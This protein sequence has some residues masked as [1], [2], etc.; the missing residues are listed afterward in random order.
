MRM[1]WVL[2]VVL[3]VGAASAQ[4]QIKGA[5]STFAANLYASWGQA[6]AKTDSRLEYEPIGS[7]GGVKAVQERIT[8][9]GA[10]DRPLPRVALEQG[11]LAQ[12][13]TAIGGVVV[14]TNI[15]GIASD[16]IK[17]DGAALAGIYLGQIKQWNDP[18]LMA[19]NPE[20]ALPAAP[21]VP[22][23]RTEGS[24]TTFVLTSYLSKVSPPFKTAVGASSTLTLASGKGAKTSNE[25]ASLVRSTPG[26]IGYFD[27]AYASDLSLP[28]VQ[29]KNQW[30][31][32][33]APNRDSLQMAMKAADWEK[34]VIDQDPTFEM[35]LTDAGCPACWPIASVTYVLVPLKGRNVNSARVLE[36]FDQSIQQGDD[37]AVKE[38]YVPLPNR[39]KNM[40]SLAMR[41]W[42]SALEKAGAGKP[43]KRVQDHQQDT[44]LAVAKL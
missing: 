40:V 20:L 25:V 26:A 9:F 7:G 15:A 33:V 14:M 42:N 28:S 10:T 34:L 41:R 35:D 4:A 16:K 36:F 21:I 6:V 39:A 27:Y 3:A 23:F 19:L 38:G 24:G 30:G 29:L 17:L 32:F 31:K 1:H 12:F 13:P 44:A 8:D 18:A 43:Q 5:G 22:V 2:G 11:G 37:N